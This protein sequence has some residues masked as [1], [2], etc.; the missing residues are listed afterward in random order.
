MIATTF[1]KISQE[2]DALKSCDV[3][4]PPFPEDSV[5]HITHQEVLKT[6][7][8]IKTKVSSCP[9]DIPAI[10]VKKIVGQLT[11]PVKDILN[12]SIKTSQWP[13]IYKVE[14]VKKKPMK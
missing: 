7:L 10:I 14:A 12:T 2:Y 13:D 5:P 3:I 8:S 6:L 11:K 9:G 1:S 4:V